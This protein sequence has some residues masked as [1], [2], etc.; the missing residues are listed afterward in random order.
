MA[1]DN[2]ELLET[3]YTE[4]TAFKEQYFPSGIYDINFVKTTDP[5]STSFSL[6]LD[7]NEGEGDEIVYKYS[8][9]FWNWAFNT[10][11]ADKALLFFSGFPN[12]DKKLHLVFGFRLNGVMYNEEEFLNI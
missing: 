12:K 3:I 5:P 9:L 4:L 11:W 6:Y 2:N 8:D 1:I 7:Y 10:A